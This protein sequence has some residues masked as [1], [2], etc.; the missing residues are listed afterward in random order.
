MIEPLEVSAEAY[1]RAIQ[2]AMGQYNTSVGKNDTTVRTLGQ[3]KLLDQ[4]SDRGSFH[5]IDNFEVSLAHTGRVLVDLSPYYY[6]TSRDVP[7]EKRDGT[8]TTMRI[9]DP[10]NINEKTRKPEPNPIVDAGDH[11]VTVSTGPSV[12]SQRMEATEF[13]DTLYGKHHKVTA[14]AATDAEAFGVSH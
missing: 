12:D 9:N 7:I 4:Q 10:A 11:N 3:A 8:R 5:L 14:S 13:A 6:D 2:A 1:K